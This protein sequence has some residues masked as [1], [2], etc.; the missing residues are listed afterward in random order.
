MANPL[1]KVRGGTG[2][3]KRGPAASFHLDVERV[4]RLYQ[5]PIGCKGLSH[6]ICSGISGEQA[7]NTLQK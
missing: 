7:E 5:P 6:G 1:D 4:P 3:S 2:P